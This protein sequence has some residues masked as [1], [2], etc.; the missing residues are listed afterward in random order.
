VVGNVYTPVYF[1]EGYPARCSYA[2]YKTVPSDAK[3]TDT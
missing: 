2:V 3:F 1:N